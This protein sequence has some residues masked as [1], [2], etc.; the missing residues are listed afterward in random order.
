MPIIEPTKINV[1]NRTDCNQQINTHPV[2]W[3]FYSSQ[4]SGPGLVFSSHFSSHY[5]VHSCYPVR[6]GF[7]LFT[8]RFVL[9]EGCFAG[10]S[11]SA[12]AWAFAIAWVVEAVTREFIIAVRDAVGTGVGMVCSRGSSR[13][14]DGRSSMWMATFIGF[15]IFRFFLRLA[16]QSGAESLPCALSA[17]TP[18]MPL[19]PYQSQPS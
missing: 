17:G 4:S 11:A 10:C 2:P 9:S 6:T 12:I 15:T 14:H 1:T 3:Q 19:F 16:P 8:S 13:L 5:S 18:S 7:S